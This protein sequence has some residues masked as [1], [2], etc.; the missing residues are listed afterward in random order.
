MI[1]I[2][3]R[4]VLRQ[5]TIQRTQF[6][7]DMNCEG[8]PDMVY[9]GHKVP[10]MIHAAEVLDNVPYAPIGRIALYADILN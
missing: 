4:D 9:G 3:N 8:K 7:E 10:L 1:G 2:W 6:E 5:F